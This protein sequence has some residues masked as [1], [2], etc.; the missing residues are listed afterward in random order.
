M[1]CIFNK[2]HKEF[3]R[4]IIDFFHSNR[5]NLLQVEKVWHAGTDQTPV[6][7]LTHIENIDYK[8]LPYEFNMCDMFR[9]ELLTDDLLFTK[10]GWIYQYNSIPN[11]KDD[12]LT[13]YWM[14]KTYNH[15][16]G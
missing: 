4:K 16:W 15:L 6:N 13:Y 11:N 3:F 8:K 9:K 7:F 1:C 10:W 2:E 12:R 5:E 14:E